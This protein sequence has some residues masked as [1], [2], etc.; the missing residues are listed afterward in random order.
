MKLNIILCVIIPFAGTCLGSAM[1][2]FL[3]N[4]ISENVQ[5]ILSGF[6]AGV[7]VAASIWSLIIPALNASA[8]KG[9]LS[10][11]PVAI[12]FLIGIGFLLL[13]DVV[14]PHIHMDSQA[15]G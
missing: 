14:T 15:E 11:I 3:K 4:Q 12:G 7:M 8:D 10:F 9:K 1:V 5:K 13:L 6:A 2:F